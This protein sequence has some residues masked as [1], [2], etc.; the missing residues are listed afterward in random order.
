MPE[1]TPRLGIK[2]PLGTDNVTREAFNENW[3]IL[4]AEAAKQT[5]L[6]THTTDAVKHITAAER[7][8]WN[9]KAN[10]AHTHTADQLPKASTTQQGIVQ[11]DDSITSTSTTSAATANAV[12]QV[13][14]AS[15]TKADLAATTAGKGA[16]LVG[17]RDASNIFTSTNVEGAL[18]ELF[19]HLGMPV[20]PV[21]P[22][23]AQF[24]AMPEGLIYRVGTLNE[25]YFRTKVAGK[26]F[27]FDLRSLMTEIPSQYAA[28]V[29]NAYN[30]GVFGRAY[31]TEKGVSA[32]LTLRETDIYFSYSIPGSTQGAQHSAAV[33]FDNLDFAG[34]N[35]V[36]V[37]WRK[38]SGTDVTGAT[39]NVRSAS[40]STS[41][42]VW[43]SATNLTDQA[44]TVRLDV[45]NIM[46]W[47]SLYVGTSTGGSSSNIRA[48]GLSVSKI[49]LL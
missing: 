28:Y 47:G 10:G 27:E 36:D 45:R 16:S 1:L 32:T 30:A 9:G 15:A 20:F 38:L 37:T 24:N 7:T 40:G 22:T 43:G 44:Q 34:V 33:I 49:T 25:P 42:V 2:K 3:D 14:D 35:Y 5:D 39:F 29:G 12:K 6:T 8:S 26:K 17:V 19:T 4:D 48:L 31:T 13:A 46:N 18:A 41:A 11:L 23:P 21:E